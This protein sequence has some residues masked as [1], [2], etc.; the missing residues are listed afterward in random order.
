MRLTAV[1]MLWWY[2]GGIEIFRGIGD[3][4]ETYLAMRKSYSVKVKGEGE[5]WVA[6]AV[7]PDL[8]ERSILGEVRISEIGWEARASQWYEFK[9]WANT[10]PADEFEM[11]ECDYPWAHKTEKP[12]DDNKQTFAHLLLDVPDF[13]N[14]L[15]MQEWQ[16][17]KG[18]DPL[19]KSAGVGAAQ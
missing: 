9:G 5:D 13:Y 10:Y 7:D 17:G 1:E 16:G 3:D 11:S 15:Q 18:E 8:L 2:D 14:K 4:G 6:Q 19:L 12:T